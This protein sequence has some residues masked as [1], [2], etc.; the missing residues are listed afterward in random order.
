[1]YI[2]SFSPP[3]Y[4][5]VEYNGLLMDNSVAKLLYSYIMIMS[6]KPLFI[7]NNNNAKY[8]KLFKK[9]I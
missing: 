7:S 2:G 9:F 3:W 6:F 5:T 4:F 8:I 1:M